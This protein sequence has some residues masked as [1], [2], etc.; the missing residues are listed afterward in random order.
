LDSLLSRYAENS[1]WLARYVE[2][3]ESLA[4]ILDVTDSFAR[5][6]DGVADWESVLKLHAVMPSY[7][8]HYKKITPAGVI[9]FFVIDRRNPF[10][11]AT[12]MAA[13]RDNA[14]TLRHLLSLELW[15]Q[16]NTLANWIFSLKPRDLS[17]HRFSALCARIKEACQLHRGIA[18][19]TL[20]R[21]Q[22]WYFYRLGRTVERCDQTTR[23]VDIKIQSLLAQGR[24]PAQD[25]SEWNALLRASAAYHG[26]RRVH[27]RGIDPQSVANFL[28]ADA[29]FPRS[30]RYC[31]NEAR[32]ALG[33]RAAQPGLHDRPVPLAPLQQIEAL[34]GD[35]P[36]ALDVPAM[37]EHLDRIQLAVMDFHLALSQHYFGTAPDAA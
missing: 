3:A 33:E 16:L 5:N 18:Q 21:D 12:D 14:R 19:N 23:V 24:D 37:H 27:P 35:P 8:E 4:R 1:Y 9:R 11:I 30:T 10:S 34:L 7:L 6:S 15:T 31:V 22:L 26:Y 17:L 25:A 2:R 32:K 13:A 29:R 28:L 36:S 20:Y